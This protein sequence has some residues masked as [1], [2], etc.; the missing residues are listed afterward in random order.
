M[1]NSSDATT[2]TKRPLQ[3]SIATVMVFVTGLSVILS[4]TTWQPAGGA[5]LSNFVVGAWWSRLAFRAERR[6]LAYYLAAWPM[7]VVVCAIFVGGLPAAISASEWE[8]GVMSLTVS[9]I[10]SLMTVRFLRKQIRTSSEH[11]AVSLGAVYLTA[12]LIVSLSFLFLGAYEVFTQVASVSVV[13][14]I[15]YLSGWL[16]AMIVTAIVATVSLPLSWPLSFLFCHILRT[17]DP[18]PP[19]KPSGPTTLEEIFQ[20][21]DEDVAGTHRPKDEGNDNEETEEGTTKDEDAK[22]TFDVT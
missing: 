15:S 18:A 10:A 6:K 13:D 20:R 7:G 1:D 9:C 16:L 12:A 5:M 2:E 21:K 22:D 4:L 3:F 19:P 14:T 8:F 11:V 17:I